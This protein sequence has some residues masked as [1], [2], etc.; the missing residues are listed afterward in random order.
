MQRFVLELINCHQF[1]PS[2]YL[3]LYLYIHPSTSLISEVSLTFGYLLL[4]ASFLHLAEKKSTGPL[5]NPGIHHPS[6]LARSGKFPF[7]LGSVQGGKGC[8]VTWMASI[9]HIQKEK[10]ALNSTTATQKPLSI[11]TTP[12]SAGEKLLVSW[13]ILFHLTFCSKHFTLLTHRFYKYLF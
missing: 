13:H 8:W 9:H 2:I 1:G 12:S 4:Q 6:S 10:N 5:K 3:P 11:F 7:P